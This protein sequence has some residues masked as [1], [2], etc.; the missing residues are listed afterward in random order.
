MPMC[1]VESCRGGFLHAE[2]CG[3]V[4]LQLQASHS[5]GL[6]DKFCWTEGG[7]KQ[8]MPIMWAPD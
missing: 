5:D 4:H 8:D 2:L 7:E 1:E 3:K 6:V